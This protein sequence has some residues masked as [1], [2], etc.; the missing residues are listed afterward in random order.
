M[1]RRA[2]YQVDLPALQ[3]TCAVNYRQLLRLL[4]QLHGALPVRRV[5]LGSGG[6]PWGVLR[7][8]TLEAS[9]YTSLVRVVQEAGPSW[10]GGPELVV[11]VYH[12]ARLAEVISARNTGHLQGVYPWP[13]PQMY[14][15][16]EKQQLNQFLGEWLRHCM[17][18]GHEP[19]PVAL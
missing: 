8:E 12:D 4:P 1:G 14:Q 3:A 6:P 9:P 19:E 10:S 7:L 5:A 2:R 13:N 16:D 18:F 17:A 11:R 15:P